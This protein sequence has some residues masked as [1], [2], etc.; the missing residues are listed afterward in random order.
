MQELVRAIEHAVFFAGL[1]LSTSGL[2][3]LAIGARAGGTW[4]ELGVQQLVGFLAYAV[5]LAI[6]AQARVPSRAAEI[7][8]VLVCV[9]IGTFAIAREFRRS[10]AAAGRRL[11]LGAGIA[12]TT[13]GTALV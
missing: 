11:L 8:V 2:G 6:A 13:L 12:G 5:L 10:H 7:A 3:R 9:A 4:R 1:L